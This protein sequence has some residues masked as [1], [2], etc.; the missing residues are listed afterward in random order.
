M[1]R[2]SA[3]L[4]IAQAAAAGRRPPP[5]ARAAALAEAVE[6]LVRATDETAS[7]LGFETEPAHI[8]TAMDETASG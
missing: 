7:G 8:M 3:D 5:E 4:I 6:T 2:I 1:A